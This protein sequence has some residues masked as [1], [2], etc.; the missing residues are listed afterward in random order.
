MPEEE[1]EEPKILEKITLTKEELTALIQI[2]NQPRNQDL[3]TA[4]FFIQLNN[5]LAKMVDEIK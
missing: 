5:K 4:G 2:L 1:K 3:Q